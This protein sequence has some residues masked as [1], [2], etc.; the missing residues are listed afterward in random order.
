MLG[1]H[2][3]LQGVLGCGYRN[4]VPLERTSRI[5]SQQVKVIL[6]HPSVKG[7]PWLQTVMH[8]PPERMVVHNWVTVKRGSWP[9][10]ALTDPLPWCGHWSI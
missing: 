5:H 2:E 8:L 1:V 7:Q 4:F 10:C 3:L 9:P 6:T